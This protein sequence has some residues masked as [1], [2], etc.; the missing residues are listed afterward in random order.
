MLLPSLMRSVFTSKPLEIQE[1]VD[2]QSKGG[3]QYFYA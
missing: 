2:D 3:V 1:K